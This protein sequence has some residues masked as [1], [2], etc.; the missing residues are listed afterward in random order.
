MD[1][2]RLYLVPNGRDSSLF[3]EECMAEAPREGDYVLRCDLGLRHAYVCTGT[4]LAWLIGYKL[5]RGPGPAKLVV[6]TRRA[7]AA[8]DAEGRKALDGFLTMLA[9]ARG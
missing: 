3:C 9:L 8:L 7:R 1:G 4:S 5:C 6:H 2:P